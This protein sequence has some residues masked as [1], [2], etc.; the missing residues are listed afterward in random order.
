[1]GRYFEK[2]PVPPFLTLASANLDLITGICFYFIVLSLQLKE[3]F[4]F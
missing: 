3:P 1:M 2:N 4:Y